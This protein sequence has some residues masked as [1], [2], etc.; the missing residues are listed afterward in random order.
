MK[1]TGIG[2]GAVV[3][4]LLLAAVGMAA[5][6]GYQGK[7]DPGGTVAFDARVRHHR[8]VEVRNFTFSDVGAM[9]SEGPGTA[10]I[11]GNPLPAMSVNAR[12]RFHGRF[13]IGGT[14][15]RARVRG[16]LKHHG[17]RAHG[18]LRLTGSF[19]GATNCDTGRDRW[20][21]RG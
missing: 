2:V 4:G 3:A 14:D 21:A 20:R 13:K 1:R 5:S 10:D 12:H 19:A 11:S 7:V 16:V 15:Q 17:K 6:R 18:R 9:C 8:A